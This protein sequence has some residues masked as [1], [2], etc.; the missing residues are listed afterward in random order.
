[1]ANDHDFTH[2]VWQTAIITVALGACLIFG[3]IVLSGGDWLPGGIIVAASAVG[4]AREVPIIRRLCSTGHVA[5]PPKHM[6]VK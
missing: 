6:S 5:S 2:Q 4:L 1:M 3:I